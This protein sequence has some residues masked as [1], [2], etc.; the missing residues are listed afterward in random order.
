MGW[1]ERAKQ[2]RAAAFMTAQT[3]TDEQ[4]LTMVSLYPEWTVGVDYGAD[5]K[6]SIV[7]S[8]GILYRAQ[9]P[10]TSVEG[11][12]P[13]NTPALWAVINKTNEGT[14]SDPIPA[15][16]GMEYVYGLYY[17][18]PD[19]GLVYLCS[20]EGAVDGDKVILQFVPHELVGQYF[21]L[22]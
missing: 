20:R 21:E 1:V 22:V 12:E 15:V 5:G 10:H 9:N 14:N 6:P 17:K 8:E 18:D 7:S 13:K 3:A 11:W 19:D 16:R 2:I 4:A